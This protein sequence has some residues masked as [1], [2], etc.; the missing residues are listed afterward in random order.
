MHRSEISLLLQ[1]FILLHAAPDALANNFNHCGEGRF[2]CESDGRCLSLKKMC[3]GRPDCADNSDEFECDARFCRQPNWFKCSEPDGLCIPS[4]L[5]CNG[6]ENCPDGE[7]EL[8]C[9]LN[10]SRPKF[11]F[12]IRQ[13]LASSKC[14]KFEFQ[15]QE[16]K[17]CIP[18]SFMCDGKKDCRDGSDEVTGC[19]KT[20]DNCKGFFCNNRRCIGS[21][22]WVC[23][24]TDDCGDA[25]DE[26]DCTEDCKPE[27]GQFLCANNKTCIELNKVCDGSVD[28]PD[29]SDESSRCISSTT[30]CTTHK[31]PPASTCHMLPTGPECIC[32]K[33][34]RLPMDSAICIDI[35]ECTEKFGICSQHCD[36]VPGGH[37]CSC[38]GG[39]LLLAD[40]RSCEAEKEEPLLLYSTQVTVAGIHL[41]SKRVFTVAQNLTKVVGLSYDGNYIYW[42]NIQKEAESIVKARL[43]HS[44]QEILLTSGL[45]SPED[46]AVDWLTGNIYFSDNVMHHIAVCS[47][48]G[49][50]CMVLVSADVHQPR[51]VALWP[52]RGEIYW[53]D[54]GDK[55]AI[56]RASMDGNDCSALVTNNIHWPNGIALDMH[57][58]RIYWV[59]AKLSTMESARPD[60]TDRRILLD[61]ILKHPYGVAVFED[62]LYWSD[63]GTRSIHSCNKFTGKDHKVLAK[64][65]A[66]YAVHIYHSAKQAKVP[67]GCMNSRC[68]HLCLLSTRNGSS[69][70]CPDGMQLSTDKVRCVK[71]RKNQRLILGIKTNLIEIEHTNFGR[72][73]IS[74]YHTLPFFISKMVFNN[75]R[76]TIFI[77][78][79]IQHVIY[80]YDGHNNN[81]TTLVDEKLGNVTAMGFDHLAHNLYWTDADRHVIEVLSLQTGHRAIISFF[82]GLE[83]PIGMAV[84]PDDGVMFVALSSRKQIHIDRFSLRGTGDHQHVFEDELGSDHFEFAVDYST[85]TLYWCDTALGRISFADYNDLIAYTFRGRLR[86]PFSI[87]I[88]DDDLFWSERK[89]NTIYWTH[90]SNLGPVKRLEI[91]PPAN[92]FGFTL[93][94]EIPLLSSAPLLTI[95]H[96]CQEANGGCSH[97]CVAV[98]RSRSACLCPAGRVFK[99]STNRTCIDL[100]DCEFR[101]RSG[102]C[103]TLSHRCNGRRDCIDGTDEDHCEASFLKSKKLICSFDEFMCRDGEKCVKQMLRCDKGQ[104]CRDGSDEE[105]CEDFDN[106]KRCH[107]YQLACG[108]GKCVDLSVMCDGA[109]DCGDNSDEINCKD[110]QRED[111]EIS[112]D[113]DMF[114][115]NSGSCIARSWQCD[116][117]LDC[118]DGSDEHDKCVLKD[119]S[120]D[121]HKCMLG[122]CLD[123]RL[124][125]DGHND[126]G[127]YSD[128]LN[129]DQ[130]IDKENTIICGDESHQMFQCSSDKSICLEMSAKCNRTTECPR[131][132]D[133]DDCYTDCSIYEFQ[134]KRSKECIRM[135][136]LCDHDKD[137]QD[138]SDE[139]NCERHPANT[140]FPPSI[141]ERPCDASMYDC[142][143]GQCVDRTRVCDGVSDCETG[144]DEG[145]LCQTACKSTS[146]TK[147]RVCAHK[148]RPTP[149][150]A[151]CSCFDGYKLEGNKRSCIDINECEE[152]DACAQICQNNIGSYQCSCFPN[153]MLRPDKTTC[154]SIES[155]SALMFSTYNEVRSMTEQPITL[156]VIWSTNDARITGFDL[157]V[158]KRMAYFSTDNENILYKVDVKSGEIKDGLFVETPTKVAVDWIT[159]NVYAISR[160]TRYSIVVCSFGDKMCGL[161][162][163]FGSRDTARAI[164]V[165]AYNRRLFTVIVR[166][167]SF[168]VPTSEIIVTNLDGKNMETI[169]SKSNSH[170]TSIACD[171]HKKL[172]YFTDAHTKTL[173]GIS[174]HSTRSNRTLT[175]FVHSANSIRHPSGITV[176]E[177]QAFI[178]NVGSKAVIRCNLYGTRNCKDFN[179]SVLNAEDILVDGLSRQPERRNPC[180]MAKCSGL[181]IQSALSYEC[182]CE[183]SFVAEDIVCP[184]TSNGSTVSS[185]LLAKTLNEPISTPSTSSPTT[186][187]LIVLLFILIASFCGYIYYRRLKQGHR[188]FN[189]NLHF[190]NPLSTTVSKLGKCVPVHNISGDERFDIALQTSQERQLNGLATFGNLRTISLEDAADGH[191]QRTNGP[192]S[193]DVR[194]RLVP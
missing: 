143:D 61:G 46:L 7:D 12:G 97:V 120:S 176:Y 164:A 116:G 4:E 76:G 3:D 94:P 88:V 129:C 151:V 170:V 86:H 39:Y 118:T 155:E 42:T 90:K 85:H 22:S 57:N 63:W 28:C 123:A 81:I 59:D 171:I 70:A 25:S 191:F 64:D 132:E 89:S 145:P 115:C 189:I 117:K 162:L 55:P 51:G 31:C 140:S 9:V 141:H 10:S 91:E 103:L 37:R 87:A 21:I 18:S 13:R 163:Q 125:C 36:N 96:S 2:A 153:F 146:A 109:D 131:G 161:I 56:S 138:G 102:E 6:I 107:R 156:R 73:R 67:H 92:R 194:T 71:T 130:S 174:Y 172:L 150:G 122:Q 69:C 75:V 149:A 100:L 99:D 8:H 134:C 185:P 136:F 112:C 139:M 24:G 160:S 38:D 14:S 27:L 23:D 192:F 169:L 154:K 79:N 54:W 66:I 135:E 181:C 29:E 84:I 15:C 45:D 77:A 93:P 187:I 183:S 113:P 19:L 47:N 43:D 1:G 83:V 60:G 106:T 68:S 34:Y 148:C 158:R 80:E 105:H 168:E 17:S 182:M 111:K 44:E 175:T 108:N 119:C 78:D 180:A 126:C 30:N 190:Q 133:E 124:V 147:N 41:K 16:D 74:K 98:G 157:N 48:D 186:I 177:N 52:E 33:G 110:R 144:A 142:H 58:K 173:Q 114:Q 152:F 53:T 159:D 193:D 40:N 179:L 50:H 104:D 35:N 11:G 128:E 82:S 65:R 121:M 5:Q 49:V 127:D 72:H 184:K 95:G 188:D 165:D 166:A 62:R 20:K 167:P 137:C 32:P 101:C 26:R 178:V